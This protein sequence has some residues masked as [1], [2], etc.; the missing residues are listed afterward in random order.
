M[1]EATAA[2][3]AT[4][5]MVHDGSVAAA[6]AL[7]GAAMKNI[8]VPTITAQRSRGTSI[9]VYAVTGPGETESMREVLGADIGCPLG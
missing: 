3:R 8:R 6:G 2:N 9:T 5:D 4:A 7:M 1:P